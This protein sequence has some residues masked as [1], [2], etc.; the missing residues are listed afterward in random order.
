MALVQTTQRV[1]RTVIDITEGWGRAWIFFIR[2]W[3]SA[4]RSPIRFNLFLNQLLQ[5]GVNSTFVIGLIGVFTGAVLSVQGNYTLAK[6]GA[7]AYTGS[8]VALSPNCA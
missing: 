6:F 4:V 2:T 8:A 5:I 7:T 3:V 1:G